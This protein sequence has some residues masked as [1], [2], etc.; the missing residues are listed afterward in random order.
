[1]SIRLCLCLLV[2]FASASAAARDV[3]LA[4]PGSGSCADSPAATADEKTERGKRAAAPARQTRA[5]PSLHS[6]SSTRTPRWHS[7][8]PG[9]FR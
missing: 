8:L 7:F 4:S 3:K 1:M 2:A 9:M 6:D 5:R